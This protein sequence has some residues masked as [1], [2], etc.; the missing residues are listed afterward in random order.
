MT[1]WAIARW[2]LHDPPSLGRLALAWAPFVLYLASVLLR[3]LR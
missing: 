2:I 3:R 1:L